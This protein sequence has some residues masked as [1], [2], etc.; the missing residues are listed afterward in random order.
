MLK[1]PYVAD[2]DDVYPDSAEVD[3]T[4]LVDIRNDI[5]DTKPEG[6]YIKYFD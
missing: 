3:T 1:A 5:L 2:P 4:S 6:I